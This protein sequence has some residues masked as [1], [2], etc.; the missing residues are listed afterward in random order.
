MQKQTNKQTNKQKTKQNKQAIKQ[1]QQQ[2]NPT[3]QKQNVRKRETNKQ[4]Q[5]EWAYTDQQVTIAYHMHTFSKS[6]EKYVRKW[7][8]KFLLSSVTVAL[9]EC[10]GHFNWCQNTTVWWSLSSQ[11]VWKKLNT[12]CRIARQCV[13]ACLVACLHVCLFFVCLFVVCL[14]A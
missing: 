1:Q 6:T 11:Q 2:Q 10:Q 7:A 12:K 14:L 8:L 3:K 5:L 13:F 4:K 9:N